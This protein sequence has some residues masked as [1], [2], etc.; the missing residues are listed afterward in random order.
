MK[1]TLTLVASFCLAAC[2]G[3]VIPPAQAQQQPAQW[4]YQV[5]PQNVSTATYPSTVYVASSNGQ[6]NKTDA[7]GD[8]ITFGSQD[9]TNIRWPGLA[10]LGLGHPVNNWGISGQT[11]G[12]IAVRM[13]AYAG[14]SQQ[15]FASGFTIPTSGTV[16][17]SFQSGYNPAQFVLGQVGTLASNV[18]IT[19]VVNGTV[20]SGTVLYSNGDNGTFTPSNYPASPVTV[21]SGAPFQV[22]TGN[23]MIGCVTIDMGQN[24]YSN[25]T[26]VEADITASVQ[27]AILHTNCYAVL[28]LL[29]GE[30]EPS[31]STK[32][33][34]I[35]AINN[36]ILSKYPK[37]SYDVRTAMVAAYNPSNAIDAADFAND[38]PAYSLRAL[39][40]RGTLSAAVTSTSQTSIALT[41]STSYNVILTGSIIKLGSEYMLVT[42]GTTGS[43]T[44]TVTRGYGGTTP[45]TYSS[46]A[47]FTSVDDFHPGQNETSPSNPLY[48]NGYKVF[49]SQYET[50]E[51]SIINSGTIAK[52]ATNTTVNAAATGAISANPLS[53]YGGDG[54]LI[55][56]NSTAWQFQNVQYLYGCDPSGVVCYTSIGAPTQSG[57]SNLYLRSGMYSQSVYLTSTGLGSTI[58]YSGNANYGWCGADFTN[59]L[60]KTATAG[61]WKIGDNA[62]G[63]YGNIQTY[64]PGAQTGSTTATL[65]TASPA[66]TATP[67]L[68]VK[69]ACGDGTGGPC[70]IPEWK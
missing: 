42:A 68:W 17:V 25:A 32:Y 43:G 45:A 14:G 2:A 39:D 9:G 23:Q 4:N 61:V 11:S 22:S 67:S 5:N 66:T 41:I 50:F 16:G 20:Y 29:N 8:S 30:N 60:Q 64:T 38:I 24:N 56:P 40:V 35:M 7:Y 69:V 53:I 19:F 31:G 63:S 6:S 58:Q 1:K 37:N 62:G 54:Q 21:P 12:S 48:N 65:G 46:G 47:S 3:G 27:A 18:P 70:Y 52:V 51:N 10:A 33:N 59:C 55:A 57:F 13:N 28:T 49:A 26:Q 36:W 34:Q 44:V 15:T